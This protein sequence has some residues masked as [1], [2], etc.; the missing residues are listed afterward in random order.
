MK[1]KYLLGIPAFLLLS[2]IFA[3]YQFNK[4][5]DAFKASISR[6]EEK[7]SILFNQEKDKRTASL[8]KGDK[9]IYELF[10]KQF[11]ENM[12][13]LNIDTAF[14]F[15]YLSKP[16]KMK[17]SSLKY[18]DCLNTK[19]IIDKQNE[20]NQKLI[21]RIKIN[22]ETKYGEIY[23]FWIK[24]IQDANHL[25]TKAKSAT[26]VN[27]FPDHYS[28]IFNSAGW[29][30]F[31][32]LLKFYN[33]KLN[34]AEIQNKINDEEYLSNV[35]SAK[36]HF[37]INVIDYFDEVLSSRKSYVLNSENKTYEFNSPIFGLITF[38]LNETRF[39]KEEF[40]NIVDKALEEQWK[41]NSLGTG[42]MPYADCY[43]SYNNCDLSCS[44]IKVKTGGSDVLVTI[45]DINQH[46]IRH[47]YINS[48]YSY[49]FEVPDGQYQVFFYSGSGWNP[50]KVMY[51]TFCGAFYGGFV[52]NENFS[53]DNYISLFSQIMT[54]ELILQKNGNLS[55]KQS[56][57]QEVF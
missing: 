16:L 9:I 50:N 13:I 24:K 26:C 54:Y 12:A 44:S 48:G 4:K 31:E 33:F 55:T 46:L 2:V 45:K 30:E 7:Q 5:F 18:I 8:L 29:K 37:R 43:G 1:S 32:N 49:S 3:R 20:I 22:L 19:C 47:A 14:S 36:N 10:S 25:K 39:N 52:A 38:D 28:V 41:N 21:E 40:Q 15:L 56:S 27:F 6:Y 57:I 23:T 35:I 11:D 42:A 17:V 53:K 34:N 51:S